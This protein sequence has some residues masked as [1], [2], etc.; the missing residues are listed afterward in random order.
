MPDSLRGEKTFGA[1]HYRPQ[2]KFPHLSNI[3]ENLYYC[4]N[5]CNSRKGAYWPTP[6]RTSIEFIPNPC[7]HEMFRHL[8]YK[9]ALVESRSRAGEFTAELLG[10]N[11]VAEVKFRE[12]I[13]HLIDVAETSLLQLFKAKDSIR[14]KRDAGTRSIDTADQDLAKIEVAIEKSRS[15]L[16]ML[17]GT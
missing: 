10:L 12:N 13:L 17:T 2:Q 15:A 7:D 16:K 1:D 6:D 4:C 3:Y 11:D 14:I 9:Q 5:A 8:R